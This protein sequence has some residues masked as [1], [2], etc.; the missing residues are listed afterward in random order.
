MGPTETSETTADDGG[1]DTLADDPG[2]TTPLDSE[3]LD[4]PET[5]SDTSDGKIKINY[6]CSSSFNLYYPPPTFLFLPPPPS[7]SP[8]LREYC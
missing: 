2:D 6:A 7:I 5:N 1:G 8:S 4:S 3:P